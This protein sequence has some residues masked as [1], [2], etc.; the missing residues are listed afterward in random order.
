MGGGNVT[1]ATAPGAARRD[2][3]LLL[4][5]T[6]VFGRLIAA[7]LLTHSALRIAVASRRGIAPR[8][9]LPGSEGRVSEQ[10]LDARDAAAIQRAIERTG[11]GVLIHAAGPYA[12]IGDAPLRAAIACGVGYADMCPRSDHF[13]AQRQR[14]HVAAERAGITAIL[15]ASTAGGLTGILTRHARRTLT[16]IDRVRAAICVH[17]FV[18]GTGVVGDYLLLA[19]RRVAAGRLGGAPARVSFPGLGLRTVTLADSL[20]YVDD[21]PDAVPDTEYRVG[22]PDLLPGL[23]MRGMA[24]VASAGIPVW[25]LARVLGWLAGP[26]GGLYTEG[27]LLH[28]AFGTGPAGIGVYETHVYRPYG[29]VRNPSLLCA[30]A[31]VRLLRG[32]IANRGIVHP[33]HWLAPD[34]LLAELAARAVVVRSRFLPEG[35]PLAQ[36]WPALETTAG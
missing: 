34:E 17:N 35:T 36:P 13:V 33:A 19:G 14:Y 31:A 18:W 32:E 20:D 3:V 1:G 10:R 27:G 28:Q 8:A 29:N 11:A 4:G 25:R 6:G 2:G 12:L 15:G 22:L 26:L 24:A 23:G 7:D 9:W 30:L 16:H 21:A 5:G